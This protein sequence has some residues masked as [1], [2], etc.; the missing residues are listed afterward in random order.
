MNRDKQITAMYDDVY[1]AVGHNAVI[2]V[3]HGG[4]IGINTEGLTRE[5]YDDGYSKVDS[6]TFRGGIVEQLRAEVAREIFEEIDSLLE[7]DEN[8]FDNVFEDARNEGDSTVSLA[9]SNYVYGIRK[10]F[11][12]LKKK[13]TEG[14]V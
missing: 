12:E 10:M 11:A 4:Y 5:L 7:S 3:T 1:E 14:G 9:L 6:V 13:Y 8:D 2:D